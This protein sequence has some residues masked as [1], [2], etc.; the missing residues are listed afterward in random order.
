[1][2]RMLKLK[3]TLQSVSFKDVQCQ[4][5]KYDVSGGINYRKHST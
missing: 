1:M 2:T 4:S 3:E 5:V